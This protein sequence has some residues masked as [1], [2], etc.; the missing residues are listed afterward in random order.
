MPRINDEDRLGVVDNHL[1]HYEQANIVNG[2]PF[3]IEVGFGRPQLVLL[4]ND[5][6][7][8]QLDIA[9]LADEGGEIAALISERDDLFGTSEEDDDGAWFWLKEYKAAVKARLGGRHPL[10]RTVPNLGRILPKN[11]LEIV[12]RFVTHWTRV[13]AALAS[14]LVMGAYTLATL[15][16]AYNNLKAKIEA[17]VD[18][19][20]LVELKRQQREQNFGDERED[21]REP[22][23]LIAW[24]L[25]YHS[26]IR[27]RF[28]NQPIADS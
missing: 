14:P 2:S 8:L 18:A 9:A 26:E 25:K 1:A 27:T 23:S 19:E 28:P 16:T 20:D 7:T 13:N 24:L 22:T 10:T 5:F 17:I 3:V 15:Q 21:K 4:R 6:E 11:Y 12:R